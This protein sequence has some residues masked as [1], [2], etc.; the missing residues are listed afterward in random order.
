MS[1]NHQL[2]LV[3]HAQGMETAGKSLRCGVENFG[4]NVHLSAE[5][6]GQGFANMGHNHHLG[7]VS[8]GQGVAAAGKSLN[9]GMASAGENL[10]SGITALGHGF[11]DM[12]WYI[13]RSVAS[14]ALAMIVRSMVDFGFAYILSMACLVTILALIAWNL[15]L[16]ARLALQRRSQSLVQTQMQRTHDVHEQLQKLKKELAESHQALSQAKAQHS[17]TTKELVQAKEKQQQTAGELEQARIL[18]GKVSNELGVARA[19]TMPADTKLTFLNVQK[20]TEL[21]QAHQ[22]LNRLKQELADA[23]IT[24]SGLETQA[25]TAGKRRRSV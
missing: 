23:K 11:A 10:N 15:H 7:L 5:A 20:E 22:E 13:S 17:V 24:I 3:A 8:H 25:D 16:Q 4:K 19:K 6:C 18:L 9:E 21:T 2:G 1:Q 12:G 14:L